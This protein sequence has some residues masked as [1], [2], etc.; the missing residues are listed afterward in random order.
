[1][2]KPFLNSTPRPPHERAVKLIERFGELYG[3]DRLELMDVLRGLAERDTNERLVF[4]IVEVDFF[5][6]FIFFIYSI[7]FYKPCSW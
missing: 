6:V 1:M 5:L 3:S 7:Q 4:C 2:T